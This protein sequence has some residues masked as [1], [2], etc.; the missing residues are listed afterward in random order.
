ETW[1][2]SGGSQNVA[3]SGSQAAM[4]LEATVRQ[5]RYVFQWT[6]GSVDPN[7]A[8]STAP[9][10]AFFWRADFW[11]AAGYAKTPADYTTPLA[12]AAVQ[13]GELALLEYSPA[14]HKIYLYRAK[15][16][17]KMDGGQVVRAAGTAAWADLANPA[18]IATF[19]SYDFVQ[20]QVISEGVTGLALNLV[21][22]RAGSRPILEFTL[23]VSRGAGSTLV[24]GGASLRTP[25]TRPL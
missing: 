20:R 10:S 4:R 18:T 2:A 24:Y 17:A 12:D 11:N 19:K 14:D 22:A 13:V 9:A 6:P 3:L 7:V 5:A 1:A 23:D 25:S 16:P 15:D 21:A 8:A